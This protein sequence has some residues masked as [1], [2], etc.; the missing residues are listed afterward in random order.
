MSGK[1]LIVVLI[2]S[3]VGVSPVAGAQGTLYTANLAG[4]GPPLSD[5]AL[6]GMRGGLAGVA[7][8]V[9]FT[10]F[11][12]PQAEFGG[13]FAVQTSGGSG[14]GA[15]PVDPST[16]SNSQHGQA[17]IATIAGSN[18]HGASGLFVLTQVP[19]SNNVVL[20]SVNIQIAI[21]NVPNTAAIPSLASV[22]R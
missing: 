15:P 3:L 6:G 18:F 11:V 22:F 17:R 7:F 8:S 21:I 4:L 19:G 2:A 9:F 1:V 16:I 20:T 10:T 5:E 14:S 12:T 13:A